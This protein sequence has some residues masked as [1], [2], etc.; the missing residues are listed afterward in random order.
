MPQDE[1]NSGIG[2]VDG[3]IREA[4]QDAAILR[5]WRVAGGPC[6]WWNC[7]TQANGQLEWAAATLLSA[8]P[9]E[10]EIG[11]IH[12]SVRQYVDGENIFSFAETD[13]EKLRS[14][15]PMVPL[16]PGQWVCRIICCGDLKRAGYVLSV[17][18]D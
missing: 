17:H 18:I 13:F 9:F 7:L 11:E 6:V 15:I 14:Q 5:S 12:V 2:T 1:F 16:T 4:R 3:R 10:V 8:D